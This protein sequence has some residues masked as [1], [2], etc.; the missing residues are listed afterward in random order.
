MASLYDEGAG[1]GV[2]ATDPLLLM[3]VADGETP[4]FLVGFIW[5]EACSAIT[6]GQMFVDM[7]SSTPV[8]Q[9]P[10]IPK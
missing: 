5:E 3:A 4:D 8:R 10:W 1:T 9:T 7:V 2:F 6:H